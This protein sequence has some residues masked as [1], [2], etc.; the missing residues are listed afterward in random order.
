MARGAM[1]VASIEAGFVED[2]MVKQT[3]YNTVI[4]G[5]G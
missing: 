1:L 4:L 5:S 2:N 3:Q